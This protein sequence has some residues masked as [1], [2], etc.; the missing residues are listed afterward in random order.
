MPGALGGPLGVIGGNGRR[1]RVMNPLG[2]ITTSV[3]DTDGELVA[4]IDP[5]GNRTTFGYDNAGNRVRTTNPLGRLQN[6]ASI[7][8]RNSASL[9]KMRVL[10]AW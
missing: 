4:T 5:L 10:S 9:V 3:Y 1:V 8:W 2:A 6:S 7:T